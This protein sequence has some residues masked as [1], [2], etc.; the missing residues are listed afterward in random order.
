M[1]AVLLFH[2]CKCQCAGLK[3][4]LKIRLQSLGACCRKTSHADTASYATSVWGRG[5]NVN[6]PDLDTLTMVVLLKTVKKN[7]AQKVDSWLIRLPGLL[8][9]S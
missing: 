5:Q 6:A 3:V 7:A 8:C 1:Q 4:Q 9:A 2:A